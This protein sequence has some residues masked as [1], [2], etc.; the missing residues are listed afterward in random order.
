MHRARGDQENNEREP[1]VRRGIAD[2]GEKADAVVSRSPTPE[3][4]IDTKRDTEKPNDKARA[5]EQQRVRDALDDLFTDRSPVGE[6]PPKVQP[7]RSPQP[8]HVLHGQWLIEAEITPL[9]RRVILRQ[10]RVF[11]YEFRATGGE[12]KNHEVEGC[13]ANQQKHGL[14]EAAYH[15]PGHRC[16]SPRTQHETVRVARQSRGGAIALIVPPGAQLLRDIPLFK[17]VHDPGL[18]RQD[19]A[20]AFIDAHIRLRFVEEDIR[21]VVRNRALDIAVDRFALGAVELL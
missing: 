1:P 11:R 19:T 21:L 6:T 9:L 2:S 4:R 10:T 8:L 5:G 16:I 12:V 13:N 14:N 20:N 15:V 7:R 3:R 18:L 17:V